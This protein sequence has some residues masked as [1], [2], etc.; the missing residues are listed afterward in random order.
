MSLSALRAVGDLQVADSVDVSN[1]P[2]ASAHRA[3]PLR[4]PGHNQVTGSQLHQG[5]QESD[6]LGNFP[7]LLAEVPLLAELVV[8]AQPDRAPLRVAD[9]GYRTDPAHWGGPVEAL[10]HVPGPS[11]L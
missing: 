9:C 10:G 2:V 4:C 11:S 1:Q 5:A 6:G 3:D 8:D 7:D